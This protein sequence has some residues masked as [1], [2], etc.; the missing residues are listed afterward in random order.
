MNTSKMSKVFTMSDDDIIK[1]VYKHPL[2]YAP[3]T[4]YKLREPVYINTIKKMEHDIHI[5]KEKKRELLNSK[6]FY[7]KLT[8]LSE[9]NKYCQ[10]LLS[11][12]NPVSGRKISI[13]GSIFRKS[14]YS[15]ETTREDRILL[16]EFNK[17]FRKLSIDNIGDWCLN[18]HFK[19]IEDQIKNI[20]IKYRSI[21]CDIKSNKKEIE[22]SDICKNEKIKKTYN[23]LIG[24]E[25]QF[26]EDLEMKYIKETCITRSGV[27]KLSDM[28][29]KLKWDDYIIYNGVKYGISKLAFIER[30]CLKCWSPNCSGELVLINHNINR[31]EC[32]RC[33]YGWSV[34]SCD[35]W[36]VDVYNYKCDT[37]NNV[38]QTHRKIVK[39]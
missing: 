28:F 36:Y 11:G 27:K 4:V 33:S 16:I 15:P 1:R 10:T 18:N 22:K 20:E 12:I 14:I 39:E 17:M 37:C 5:L 21:R 2:R 3:P 30:N 29:N 9:K 24:K 13:C 32:K 8:L 31:R 38:I 25:K 19:D 35:C 34:S 23:E 6:R 26:N 7:K